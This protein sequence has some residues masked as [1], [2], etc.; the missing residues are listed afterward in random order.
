VLFPP[1]VSSTIH[2]PGRDAGNSSSNT[3]SPPRHQIYSFPKAATTVQPFKALCR[4]RLPADLP[5]FKHYN[6]INT[7]KAGLPAAGRAQRLS[8]P[9][10]TSSRVSNNPLTNRK[11]SHIYKL[12]SALAGQ[13]GGLSRTRFGKRS[14]LPRPFCYFFCPSL[15]ASGGK[16]SKERKQTT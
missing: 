1:G 16:K 13:T 2:V 6:S 11:Q 10:I 9:S 7:F 12:S 15:S 8:L 4:V 5:Y 3:S 14:G